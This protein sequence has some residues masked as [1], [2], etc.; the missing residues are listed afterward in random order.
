MLSHVKKLNG[1][2]LDAASYQR[3]DIP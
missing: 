1:L 2:S 3:T